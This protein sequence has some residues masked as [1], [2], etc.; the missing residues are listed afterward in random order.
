[1]GEIKERSLTNHNSTLE[2]VNKYTDEANA[3]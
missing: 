3:I 2:R 1:M